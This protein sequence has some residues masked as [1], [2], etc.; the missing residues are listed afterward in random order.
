[1]KGEVKEV[2]EKLL[3]ILTMLTDDNI[4]PRRYV[5]HSIE[6]LAPVVAHTGK[7]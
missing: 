2:S 7:V 6:R 4:S 1:L 5:D 3:T